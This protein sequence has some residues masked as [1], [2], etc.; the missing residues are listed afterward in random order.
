ML[1]GK[2][3]GIVVDFENIRELLNRIGEGYLKVSWKEN[4]SLKSGYVL[5]SSGRI[6]GAIV[7][8]ILSGKTLEGEMAISEISKI[9]KAKKVRVVELYDA[10]VNDILSEMPAVR[11][12]KGCLGKEIPGWDLETLLRLL[13]SCTGELQVHNGNISWRLYVD[14]GTIKAAK[15]VGGHSLRGNEAF[16]A[17]LLNMGNIMK[18]GKYVMGGTWKFNRDD[19]VLNGDIFRKGVEMLIEKKQVE[20]IINGQQQNL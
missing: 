4:D 12:D 13:A 19:I 1:P 8:D 16:R 9:A 6:V 18:E 2:F 15:T 10:N 20:K 17:L 5:V 11:V 3:V 14:K 7:E